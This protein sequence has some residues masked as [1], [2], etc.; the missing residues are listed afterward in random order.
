MLP[1]QSKTN[2][3]EVEFCYAQPVYCSSAVGLPY[4]TNSED[5]RIL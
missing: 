3:R 4:I 1:A 2:V 5:T